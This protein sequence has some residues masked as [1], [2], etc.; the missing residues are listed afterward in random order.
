MD[1]QSNEIT[2]IPE[3]L[4]VLALENTPVTLDA[5]GCQKEIAQHILDRQ[6]DYL[7][8]LKANQGHAYVAVR[9]YSDTHCFDAQSRLATVHPALDTIRA[10]RRGGTRRRWNRGRGW[11]SQGRG[12]WSQGRG[13]RGGRSG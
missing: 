2:A 8:V 1:G 7:L 5:M 4:Q 6:A 3:R 13:R 9:D 12:W 10:R 11:W